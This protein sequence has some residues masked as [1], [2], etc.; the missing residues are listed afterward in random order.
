M[1]HESRPTLNVW[2]DADE[3]H[4]AEQGGGPRQL[5]GLARKLVQAGAGSHLLSMIMVVLDRVLHVIT[6]VRT[7]AGQCGEQ[8][9]ITLRASRSQRLDSY[10]YAHG[11][12]DTIK[13]CGHCRV[14]DLPL[15]ERSQSKCGIVG[16]MDVILSNTSLSIR[17][18][19][20]RW[21]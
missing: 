1:N 19:C 5:G 16:H 18:S 13:L 3:E 7:C 10:T 21:H 6:R 9:R 2:R 20:S 15:H 17:N 4:V 14:L 11:D 12:Q 8:A